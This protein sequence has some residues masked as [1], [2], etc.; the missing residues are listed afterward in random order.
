MVNMGLLHSFQ[1]IG[2]T[3]LT[4]QA[5]QCSLT[6]QIPASGLSAVTAKGSY[7]QLPH[8]SISIEQD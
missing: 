7:L 5:G 2:H 3:A 4:M 6:G 8:A 1:G